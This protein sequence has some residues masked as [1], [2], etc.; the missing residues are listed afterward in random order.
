MT[1]ADDA[2]AALAAEAQGC[3]A[4]ELWKRGTQ[5]VLGAKSRVGAA[6]GTDLELDGHR[7]VATIHPCAI[8]RSRSSEER[9][10]AYDGFVAD[11]RRAAQLAS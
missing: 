9:A 11:L 3:R 6:R 10:D 5:T 8:P 4:C 7:V 2:L 1:K